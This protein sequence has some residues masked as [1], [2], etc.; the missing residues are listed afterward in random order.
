MVD[1]E[2]SLRDGWCRVLLRIASS[3]KTGRGLS[4]KPETV[5]ILDF[6]NRRL[7]GRSWSLPTRKQGL[8]LSQAK[9][10]RRTITSAFLAVIG[11]G[12][13][14]GVLPAQSPDTLPQ[15]APREYIPVS[16]PGFVSESVTGL[17]KIDRKV[18]SGVRKGAKAY[19]IKPESERPFEVVVFDIS[20]EIYRFNSAKDAFKAIEENLRKIGP[21]KEDTISGIPVVTTQERPPNTANYWIG[22]R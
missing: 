9:I 20:T 22:Y 3:L 1:A 18:M 11:Y 8:Q 10:G 19:W 21:L 17:S 6:V 14:V 7:K 4:I 16:I 15:L 13:G 5:G 12:L 2:A